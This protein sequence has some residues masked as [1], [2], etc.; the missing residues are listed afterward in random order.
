MGFD[1]DLVLLGFSQKRVGNPCVAAIKKAY[2]RLALQ[3]HPDKNAGSE[4]AAARFVEINGAYKRVLSEMKVE[5]SGESTDYLS[6][7]ERF[8]Q[9]FMAK[10]AWD[11][12]F[13]E[14]SLSGI[15]RDCEGWSIETFNSLSKDKAITVFDFINKYREVLRVS[16]NL[17][18]KM[19]R[20]LQKKMARDNVVILNPSLAEILKDRVFKLTVSEREFYIPLWHSEV[21]YDISGNDLIVRCIPELPPSVSID[22]SNNIY[23]KVNATISDAL[24]DGVVTL[25]LGDKVFTIPAEELSIRRNQAYVFRNVGMLQANHRNLF[26]TNRRAHIYVDIEFK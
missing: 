13:I 8:V 22:D 17:M 5:S 2:Y 24:T 18:E 10:E 26:D 14:T 6:L 9:M 4:E 11:E 12:V 23:C 7:L 19:K 15:I 16:D 1:E 20:S 3:Y 21:Y 25:K